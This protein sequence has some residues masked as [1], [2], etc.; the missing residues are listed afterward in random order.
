MAFAKKRKKE[1]A[2]WRQG[3][4]DHHQDRPSSADRGEFP[5]KVITELIE[6]AK[7]QCQS[8][9]SAQDTTTHHVWPR[10]R[11]G[12]G[13]KQN[14]LRLCWPCHDRIQTSPEELQHWIDI[15]RQRYGERFWYDEQDWEEY[16]RKQA[17]EQAEEEV[18]RQQSE[19]VEPVVSLLTAAAGRRLKKKELQ[20]IVSINERDLATLAGLLRDCMGTHVL[21]DKGYG[22]FKD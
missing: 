8:C 6:E 9:R 17:A 18:K 10:G 3:I 12:R 20:Y 19:R 22:W 5:R 2:P 16:N 15:Y 14:G 7:G 21:D 11:K 4:L 1:V 13:V